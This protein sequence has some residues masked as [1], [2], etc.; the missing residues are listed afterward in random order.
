MKSSAAK[1]R[2]Y[3]N[4]SCNSSASLGN[5]EQS[6]LNRAASATSTTSIAVTS[7]WLHLLSVLLPVS[8]CWEKGWDKAAGENSSASSSV[9]VRFIGYLPGLWYLMNNIAGKRNFAF[10]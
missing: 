8:I 6:A 1:P 9:I 2:W 5:I 3:I 4:D 10:E 7:V